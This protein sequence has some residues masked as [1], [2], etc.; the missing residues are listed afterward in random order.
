MSEEKKATYGQI[1][2]SWKTYW[3]AFVFVTLVTRGDFIRCLRIGDYGGAFA[4][5]ASCCRDSLELAEAAHC[6]RREVTDRR[7]APMDASRS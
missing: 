7:R 3:Y 6:D 5:G 2:L 4:G 1:W